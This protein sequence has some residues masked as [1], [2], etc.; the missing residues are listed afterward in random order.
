MSDLLQIAKV[1]LY[2]KA[3]LLEKLIL[4]KL[5]ELK[6]GAKGAIN[7]FFEGLK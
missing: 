5:A 4:G 6:I 2:D 1:M 3:Q 7:Q